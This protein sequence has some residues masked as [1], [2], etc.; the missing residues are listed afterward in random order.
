LQQPCSRSPEALD[1][2]GV[3]V[4]DPFPSRL[5]RRADPRIAGDT[6]VAQGADAHLGVAR[7]WRKAG[8]PERADE[9]EAG[10]RSAA[11]AAGWTV[12]G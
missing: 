9:I 6:T 4:A 5:G 7:A 2:T 8:R 10:F 1:L 3:D 11:H 12:L